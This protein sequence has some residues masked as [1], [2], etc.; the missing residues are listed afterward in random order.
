MVRLSV[1]VVLLDAEDLLVVDALLQVVGVD[2]ASEDHLPLEL[3]LFFSGLRLRL[4]LL[5]LFIF[6]LEDT[7]P[8]VSSRPE[9]RLHVSWVFLLGFIDHPHLAYD[10]PVRF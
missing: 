9:E 2:L 3:T 10:D 6:T 5:L 1:G 8:F 7:L 4:R